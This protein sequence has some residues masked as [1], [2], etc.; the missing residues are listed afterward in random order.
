MAA[1]NIKM[2]WRFCIVNNLTFIQG[3]RASKGRKKIEEEVE[4]LNWLWCVVDGK[5]YDGEKKQ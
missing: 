5:E 4:V 3:N 2:G 1:E